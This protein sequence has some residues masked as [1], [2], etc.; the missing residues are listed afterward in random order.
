VLSTT[1]VERAAE[2][3]TTGIVGAA[4]EEAGVEG[5]A[6][7]SIGVSTAGAALGVEGPPA[8]AAGARCTGRAAGAAGVAGLVVRST[9]AVMV[10]QH[11]V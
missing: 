11:R 3:L 9:A 2:H 10:V 7:R 4:S 5:L 1:E 8:G 6:V